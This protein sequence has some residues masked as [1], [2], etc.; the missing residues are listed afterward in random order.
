MF[1]NDSVEFSQD[2][3]IGRPLEYESELGTLNQPH[4]FWYRDNK[5][6]T[7]LLEVDG[8]PEGHG[9]RP[10]SLKVATISALMADVAKGQAN[11]SQLASQWNYMD[12]AAQ[13]MDKA[14]SR[15]IA[16]RRLPASNFA[17]KYFQGN[18]SIGSIVTGRLSFR[19]GKDQAKRP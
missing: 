11:L 10:H 5:M 17:Q 3:W 6:M 9:I 12:V 18:T 15:N 8:L 4:A 2:F 14:Y 19:M 7:Y 16:H 13:D 1:R